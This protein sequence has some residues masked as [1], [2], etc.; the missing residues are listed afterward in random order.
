MVVVI[1]E[2]AVADLSSSVS[3]APAQICQARMQ[4]AAETCL[5]WRIGNPNPII[6][7]Q[8]LKRTGIIGIGNLPCSHTLATFVRS[9]VL[10]FATSFS[11]FSFI[12]SSFSAIAIR[13]Q[14]AFSVNISSPIVLK[15]RSFLLFISLF[16]FLLCCLAKIYLFFFAISSFLY[17]RLLTLPPSSSPK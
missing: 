15:T 5:V 11:I 1:G 9:F 13:S 4:S 10:F 7:Q 12:N 8:H 17:R 2:P 6:E 16:L 3:Y 14:V